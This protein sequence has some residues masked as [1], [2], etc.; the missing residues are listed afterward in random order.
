MTTATPPVQLPQH[1]SEGQVWSALLDVADAQP[2]GWTLVGALMVM[3]HAYET[4]IATARATVTSTRWFGSA[5]LRTPPASSP[6]RSNISGGNCIQA[7]PPATA[8]PS[9]T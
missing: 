7:I 2:S 8:S 9:A 3:L 6:R 5:E 1:G 4:G